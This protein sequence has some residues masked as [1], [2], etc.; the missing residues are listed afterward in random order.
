MVLGGLRLYWV[1]YVILG[2]IGWSEM[3]LG[4]LVVGGGIWWPEMVLIGLGSM[5]LYWVA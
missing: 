5:R 4:G 1:V 3:A 2:G